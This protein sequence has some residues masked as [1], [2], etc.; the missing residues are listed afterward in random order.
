MSWAELIFYWVGLD[1]VSSRS[2]FIC[3]PAPL[4]ALFVLLYTTI[5]SLAYTSHVELP[6]DQNYYSPNHFALTNAWI[7]P[8]SCTIEYDREWLNEMLK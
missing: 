7:Y 1:A 8:V 2:K 3:I 4:F 6:P 5:V